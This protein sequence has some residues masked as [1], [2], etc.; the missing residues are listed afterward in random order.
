MSPHFH[1]PYGCMV[2]SIMN[3]VLRG[4]NS[5]F[6]HK[7]SSQTFKMTLNKHLEERRCY[8][9]SIFILSLKKISWFSIIRH[10]CASLPSRNLRFFCSSKSKLIKFAYFPTAYPKKGSNFF[11]IIHLTA[12]LSCQVHKFKELTEMK[13]KV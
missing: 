6:C 2:F 12:L 7:N 9:Y 3:K 8:N 13:T 5:R 4:K 11:F 10:Y 1:F